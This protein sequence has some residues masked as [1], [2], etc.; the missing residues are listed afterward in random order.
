MTNHAAR[1]ASPRLSQ[2]DLLRRLVQANEREI[3][4]IVSVLTPAERAR[5]AFFCYARGHLHE[6]GLA[7]AATCDLPFLMQA[8]PSN[9]AGNTLFTRSRERFTATVER[10]SR[11]RPAVTLAKS[12]MSSDAV[13]RM[14]ASMGEDGSDLTVSAPEIEPATDM[15]PAALAAC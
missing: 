9:A 12:A 7:V 15:A 13:A 1:A 5:L 6:I 11:R 4:E 3:A 10:I 2:D 14:M 8:A